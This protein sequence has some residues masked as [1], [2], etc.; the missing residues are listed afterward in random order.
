MRKI[1]SY[2]GLKKLIGCINQKDLQFVLKYISKVTNNNIRARFKIILFESGDL[3]S[4]MDEIIDGYKGGLLRIEFSELE[5]IDGYF[6][7]HHIHDN[8]IIIFNKKLLN[9]EHFQ[10]FKNHVT[11]RSGIL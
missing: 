4:D 3:L 2:R 9:N 11:Y 8:C 7:I 1:Y 5:Y 10:Y 6:I